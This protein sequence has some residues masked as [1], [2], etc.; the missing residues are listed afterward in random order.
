MAIELAV[1]VF[2]KRLQQNGRE[3][4]ETQLLAKETSIEF[5]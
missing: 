5:G 4:R 2:N 3:F 1:A